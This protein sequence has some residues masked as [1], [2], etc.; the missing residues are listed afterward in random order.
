MNLFGKDATSYVC[1][2]CNKLSLGKPNKIDIFN[3]TITCIVCSKKSYKFECRCKNIIWEKEFYYGKKNKC[4]RCNTIVQL[5]PC[6]YFCSNKVDEISMNFFINNNNK[7]NFYVIGVSIN[8]FHCHRKYQHINCPSCLTPKYFL[9]NDYELGSKQICRNCKEIFFHCNCPKCGEAKY[10]FSFSYG[11]SMQCNSCMENFAIG[12]CKNCK[13]YNYIII[14]N[15]E[16]NVNLKE[17]KCNF[18]AYKFS[19]ISCYYCKN[20]EYLDKIED[21]QCK[22]IICEKEKKE[23]NVFSCNLCKM[24]DYCGCI[25]KKGMHFCQK[26]NKNVTNNSYDDK[27]CSICYE[28]PIN[29]VF[30]L[31]GHACSCLNCAKK[32]E[33]CPFC[34]KKSKNVKLYF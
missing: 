8:C 11:S 1:L 3:S 22:V 16:K 32:L 12:I 18:C 28:N 25:S 31:C 20:P 30:S 10:S 6:G 29:S 26:C 27:I 33:K 13:N 2:F 15:E 17:R 23:Y 4:Q 21:N 9:N 7:E 5:V 14:N 34:G 19:I 24:I